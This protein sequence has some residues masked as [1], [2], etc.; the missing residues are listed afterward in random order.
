MNK[1]RLSIE[2][3]IIPMQPDIKQ[4]TRNYEECLLKWNP[5]CIKNMAHF[6][7]FQTMDGPS[8]LEIIP[9][10]CVNFFFRCGDSPIAL[11]SGFNLALEARKLAPATTY[12]GVK[13]YTMR[14]L[15]P[16][17][18][19]WS[20]TVGKLD[21]FTDIFG[22]ESLIEEISLADSFAQRIRLFQE[23]AQ[24]HL[25]DEH[26]T[27]DLVEYTEIIMCHARGNVKIGQLSDELGYTDRYCRKRFK[28]ALGIS[29]KSYSE[30][31]RFQNAV[32]MMDKG[33]SPIA[34]VI[35]DNQY[36]DQ[37]HLIREFKKFTD[38]TPADFRKRYIQE[39]EAPDLRKHTC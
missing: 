16:Q 1:F 2:E 10:S 23:F 35:Y 22:E 21:S 31:L 17:K 38:L 30:T 11:V 19:A 13:P 3:G 6:F 34:D 4:K 5:Y 9:D 14:G 33:N 15:K 8:A 37:S 7:Q 29:I 12:F 20:E 39:Q 36:Y 24:E 27:P 26:Y 18:I 32:R 28:E 25:I